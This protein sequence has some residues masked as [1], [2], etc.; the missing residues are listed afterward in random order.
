VKAAKGSIGRAVDQPDPKIRFYLFYG[1]DEGQSR[2]LGARL[3]EALGAS[4]TVVA[5]GAIKSGAAS[6][7]DEAGAMSL[8]GGKQLIWVEPAGEDIA[9]SVA[10]LL[11]APAPESAVVAIGGAL[12]KTSGL[13][14]LAEAS[15]HALAFA[16]YLPE[17]EQ[18]EQ[19]VIDVGRRFGLKISAPVAARLA[20]H[21][22]NDQAIVS[23][24]L[25]K[26]ATYL[27]ASPHSPKELGHEAVDAVGAES[28]DGAML[29]LADF[30]LL[31]D[32]RALGEGIEGL[33][34]NEGITVI[35]S[36]QRRLLMLAPI[37]ARI[38]RGERPDAVMASMGRALFFKEKDNV[39]AMLRKW[40]AE[41]L[42]KVSDRAAALE[43]ELMFT[44]APE[45]EALGE[46]LL[47]IGRKARSSS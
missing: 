36:L 24:E 8:F 30:A 13:L 44:E 16:S 23:Q 35:R 45:K 15:P 2:G 3:L 18:A 6:L 46:A 32:M 25:D 9:E 41:D 20:D 22:A 7:A 47:A 40:S 11:D 17:G 5:A 10:A 42:A 28:S 19:M 1:P 27:D 21:C 34:G 26:L 33:S 43:R 14:K 31:G 12:R 37:R 29:K 39:A 38:E 4:K